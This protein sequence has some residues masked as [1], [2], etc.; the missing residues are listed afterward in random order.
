MKRVALLAVLA[1]AAVGSASADSGRTLRG[2]G[3]TLS[4][5]AGWHG[6]AGPAGFQAADF[7]LPPRARSSADLVR[8]PRGHV[9]LIVWNYGPWDEYLPHV[10]PTPTPL[11]LR[12]RNL[13]GP[14]EG[15]PT[16]DAFALRTARVGG[17]MLEILAD[18]GPK[19]FTEP[20]LRKANAA[21]TTLHVLPPRLLRPRG[22]RLAADGVAVRRLPGWS[23]HVEIPAERYGA[24]L[25]L[26]AAHGDVHVELLE[27]P[28]A[29]PAPHLD[30]PIAFASR[31][32]FR[33]GPLLYA[34]RAFST[35]GRSFELSVAVPSTGELRVANRFLATLTVEPRPWTFRS[36]NLR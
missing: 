14:F 3:M 5:P 33:R 35:G 21:L 32:T 20:A 19:P 23:G 2:D 1:L 26:R 12:R 4:L 34:H 24:R 15:F 22:G 17:D 16:R 13:G 10:R 29:D 25:V 31:Q 6:L 9:H 7:P 8:V 30:L 11:V 28:A 27:I 18:L 36:C